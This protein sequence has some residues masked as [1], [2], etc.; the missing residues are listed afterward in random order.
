MKNKAAFFA[1][2]V[3]MLLLSA[4]ASGI[5]ANATMHVSEKALACY[6]N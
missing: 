6:G 1:Q 2:L 3:R 5:T 4:L